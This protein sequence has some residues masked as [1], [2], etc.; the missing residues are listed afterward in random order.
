MP[1][2]MGLKLDTNVIFLSKQNVKKCLK[3]E[4]YYLI[5]STQFTVGI[6]IKIAFLQ[7]M[8]ECN[9]RGNKFTE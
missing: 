9:L 1:Y 8:N 4:N 3:F 6:A 2:N 7:I 5:R